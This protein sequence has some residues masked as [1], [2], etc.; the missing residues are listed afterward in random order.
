MT[1]DIFLRL[2]EENTANVI[3]LADCSTYK[4]GV[5]YIPRVA[6]LDD[7]E[8]VRSG[9]DGGDIA[10]LRYQN[11]VETVEWKLK[12]IGDGMLF[13]VD[14]LQN[15]AYKARQRQERGFGNR[16]FVEYR[17]AGMDSADDKA[18][19]EILWLAVEM[20]DEPLSGP[21]QGQMWEVSVIWKRRYFWESLS[22]VEL[23]LSNSSGSGIG[24]IDV[25]N[26]HD[27]NP[28]TD[29]NYVNILKSSTP[30]G[31]LPAPIKLELRHDTAGGSPPRIGVV[32]ISSNLNSTPSTTESNAFQNILE[33]EDADKGADA[34]AMTIGDG[35]DASGDIDQIDYNSGSTEFTVGETVTGASSG[36]TGEVT[37]YTLTSGSWGGGDAAG[38]LYMKDRSGTF[39]NPEDLNGS[40]GGANMATTASAISNAGG[41]YAQFDW[42]GTGE[43]EIASWTLD[44]TYL[45]RAAGNWFKIL[46]AFYS[47]IAG[48]G[49]YQVKWK[50]KLSVTTIFE[51]EW[52][53][54]NN[55]YEL[56]EMHGEP[57]RLP[58][59]DIP[60]DQYQLSLVLTVKH[61]ASGS[62]S[63][64]IDFLQVSPLDGWR[65]LTS[66]ALHL[67]SGWT[68]VDNPV[69]DVA[70]YVDTGGG[71][72]ANFI[73][74]G[75]AIML[76]PGSQI[77][78]FLA[79]NSTGNY[80]INHTINVRAYTRPRSLLPYIYDASS[81]P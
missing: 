69:D 63:L 26:H 21:F 22:E 1:E 7:D 52:Y 79:R 71:K 47:S 36:A 28:T 27:D 34:S 20:P 37:H 23:P 8:T 32:Y 11:V 66:P 31:R 3:T 80:Q 56:Q 43:A 53:L 58:P 78:Y 12:G 59:Q 49:D 62:H 39:S 57:I 17:P 25:I 70:P 46:G 19:S 6:Q 45:N 68:L 40:T 38:V 33:A 24:G 73:A 16:I 54:L 18:R 65:I 44:T 14:S 67:Q 72:G 61:S 13:T 41:G 2:I 9:Q 77:L 81:S 51:T 75:D 29:D 48:S 42:S 50:L 10:T 35:T 5:R 15:F 76:E 74:L 4:S 30:I 55:S 64:V 60:D